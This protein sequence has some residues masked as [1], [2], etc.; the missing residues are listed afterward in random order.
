M[1][2]KRLREGGVKLVGATVHDKTH[3]LKVENPDRVESELS[4][5]LPGTGGRDPSLRAA[6]TIKSP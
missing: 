2:F 1:T 6:P 4:I 5:E 3:C